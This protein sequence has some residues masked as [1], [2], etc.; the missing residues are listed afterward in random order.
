MRRSPGRPKRGLVTTAAAAFLAGVAAA[1]TIACCAGVGAHAQ[2]DAL[3]QLKAQFRRPAAVPFPAT[4][5]FTEDKRALGERLFHDKR[6][7]VDGSIACASCHQ[8]AKGFADGRRQG[9]GVP[10]VALKR[11]T[12]TLWNL[13]WA[14]PVF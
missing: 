2:A 9:R 5:P 6:L 3:A 13:A 7:S 1:A 8:R 11:H 14:G 12:P 10:G 4:N